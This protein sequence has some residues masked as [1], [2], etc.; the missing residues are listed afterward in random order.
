MLAQLAP[1]TTV[2]GFF[3]NLG[4]RA[5]QG[6]ILGILAWLY[7][8]LKRQIKIQRVIKHAFV[9]LYERDRAIVDLMR[10]VVYK[11]QKENELQDW[12][13]IKRSIDD[14]RDDLWQADGN[15]SRPTHDGRARRGWQGVK[16]IQAILRES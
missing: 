12:D 3:E 11:Q 9:A 15:P 10:Q 4:L 6:V 8:R 14:L 2:P 13:S 16:E 1:I 5:L 7:G